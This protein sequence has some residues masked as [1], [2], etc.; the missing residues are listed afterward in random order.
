MAASLRPLVQAAAKAVSGALEPVELAAANARH[1]QLANLDAS[2]VAPWQ[3]LSEQFAILES[4]LR[5]RIMSIAK[6]EAN[7]ST[8][9]ANQHT[10]FHKADIFP[11]CAPMATAALDHD[12]VLRDLRFRL[13]PAHM[14]EEAFWRCYFWHVVNIKCELLHDWS[15]ANQA[16]REA[17]MQDETTLS[18]EETSMSPAQIDADLDAE[19]ERL[20]NSANT[21]TDNSALMQG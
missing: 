11:G 18:S 19:F 10:A 14:S 12:F 6:T 7:F 8:S 15:T 17:T 5:Q 21:T 13:V 1:Q 20:V 3:T 4:E 16:R 9:I 2:G